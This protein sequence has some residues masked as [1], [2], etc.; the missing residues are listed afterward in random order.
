M[1]G[2][3]TIEYDNQAF[4]L[5]ATDIQRKTLKALFG[6]DPKFLVDLN[7][8]PQR[9]LVFDDSLKLQDGKRYAIKTAADYENLSVQSLKPEIPLQNWLSENSQDVQ[10]CLVL[11]MASYEDDPRQFLRDNITNHTIEAIVR[12]TLF[13]LLLQP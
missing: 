11:S 4:D 10:N 13:G 2:T 8:N 3:V 9:V 12:H 7:T 6:V 1:S 5:A